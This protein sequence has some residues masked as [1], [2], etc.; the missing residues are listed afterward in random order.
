[1]KFN[2]VIGHYEWEKFVPYCGFVSKHHAECV[3]DNLVRYKKFHSLVTS[4]VLRTVDST[5]SLKSYE[6]VK[7]KA[8]VS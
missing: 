4:V 5:Q 8:V 3:L 2:Y 6:V 7:G 1:M